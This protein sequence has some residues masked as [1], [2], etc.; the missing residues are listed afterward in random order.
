[1]MASVE[2]LGLRKSFI[3]QWP[4]WLVVLVVALQP[5]GRLPEVPLLVMA[6]FGLKDVVSCRQELFSNLAFRLFSLLFLCFWIPA[7][8]SLP[9]AVNVEKGLSSTF[10]MLRFYLAGIFIIHRL[11]TLATH[12]VLSMAVAAILAFWALDGIVEL[13]LGHDIFGLS[14]GSSLYITGVYG[15]NK[16]LGYA[17]VAFLGVALAAIVSNKQLHWGVFFSMLMAFVIFISGTRMAWLALAWFVFY[18]LAMLWFAGYRP[19]RKYLTGALAVLLLVGAVGSQ[20]PPVQMKVFRS[21]AAINGS[22]LDAASS[23]RISIWQTSIDMFSDNWINGVGVRGFRYA[24]ADYSQPDDRF[25]HG[26]EQI[27]AYHPHQIVLE[28]MAEMGVIGVTGLLGALLTMVYLLK[29]LTAH[30]HRFSFLYAVGIAT[31]LMPLNTH[32]SMYSSYWASL[33]WFLAALLFA[34]VR[35]E[36]IGASKH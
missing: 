25:L 18:T 1:M 29:M 10:G 17:L 21:V 36:G 19:N 33:F 26:E 5:I 8:V 14:S 20:T 30:T 23:G 22:S 34:V 13:L 4:L 35:A 32:L 28:M 15:D 12:R 16:R 11:D 2:K 24:Y 31:L 9:D 3:E 7:L 6:L 27:G